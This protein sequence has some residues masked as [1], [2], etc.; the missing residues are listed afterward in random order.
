MIIL[1][2]NNYLPKE[3]QIKLT[4]EIDNTIPDMIKDLK[5]NFELIIN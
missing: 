1:S 4:S 3:N 2:E 5:E